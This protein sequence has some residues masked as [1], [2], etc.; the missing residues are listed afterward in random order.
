MPGAQDEGK[1]ID[2][3]ICETISDISRSRVQKLMESGEVYAGSKPCK[4]NARVTAGVTITLTLPAPEESSVLPQNIPLDIVYEDD[5]LIVVNKPKGMVVHPAPGNPDGTLVNA[6][7]YHCA[8]S[9]SG[10][11]GTM[12]P[13]IVHRIDKLT[14]GL[15][16]SAKTDAAHMRLSSQLKDHSLRRVYHAIV[17]GALPEDSGTINAPIGRS[18]RDRKKMAVTGEGRPAVTHYEVIERYPGYTY[19]RCRLETGRT[20]QIRVHFKSLGHPVLGDTVYGGREVKGLEG[21][22][23]HAISI[24]FIHPETEEE[25]ELS[26]P[27]PEYF[28]TILERM[29]SKE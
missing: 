18:L 27:L 15:I 21:Q 14:S 3:Y 2:A 22:C 16:I 23:L 10:I 9:L 28:Q 17:Q 12:R 1:R 4:K 29:R 26:C 13:G 24:A 11:G 20:H 5:S 7:L 8:G 6:L 19:V 25:M